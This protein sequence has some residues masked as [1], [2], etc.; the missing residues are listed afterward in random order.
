MGNKIESIDD[1]KNNTK[2]F[3]FGLLG[4][5]PSDPVRKCWKPGCKAY[6]WCKNDIQRL[7]DNPAGGV[8]YWTK[9]LD[10]KEKLTGVY[11]IGKREFFEQE[12][13]KEVIR[14][15]AFDLIIPKGTSKKI[16]Y[17]G[18]SGNLLSR[19]GDMTGDIEKHATAFSPHPVWRWRKEEKVELNDL[20]CLLLITN[21]KKLAGKIEQYL[22][23]ENKRVYDHSHMLWEYTNNK[24]EK[25]FDV[26]GSKRYL[27]KCTE[28]EDVIEAL[29]AVKIIAVEVEKA[30]NTILQRIIDGFPDLSKIT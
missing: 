17:S 23:G 29:E 9:F 2:G 21:D 19:L 14:K 1:I 7:E 18:K 6:E 22:H 4:D 13:K 15:E 24:T 28:I 16:M 25:G 8:K 27:S 20:W 26:Y 11:I 10:K 30:K 12:F 5:F 3:A